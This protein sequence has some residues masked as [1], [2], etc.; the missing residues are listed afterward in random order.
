MIALAA[1]IP[2]RTTENARYVIYS[3]VRNNTTSFKMT[4]ETVLSDY[5]LSKTVSF[6]KEML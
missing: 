2:W 6:T 4:S 5:L 1:K 3:K